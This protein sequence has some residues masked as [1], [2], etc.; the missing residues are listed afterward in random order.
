MN[1]II[2]VDENY[3]EYAKTM[4]FSLACNNDEKIVVYL[5][6]KSVSKP[7]L[8]QFARFMEEKCHGELRVVDIPAE[9]F[10]DLP[11][12]G[13]LSEETYYRLLAF[14]LL[15]KTVERALWLDADIIVKGNIADFY[16]TDFD[17]K[18]AAACA[19]DTLKNH[20]RLGLSQTHR[21]FNAGVILFNL[22]AM[23]QRF[24]PADVFSCIE[25]HRDHLDCM[26]QDVLNVLL[27]DSVKYVDRTTYNNGAFGFNILGKEKMRELEET[28][29]IIHYW[30]SVKPW[31][32]K[33]ANWADGY[34]WGYEWKR[35]DHYSCCVKYRLA[36]APVKVKHLLREVY[37]LIRGQLNRIR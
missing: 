29:R 2:A 11:S 24:S 31:N 27:M 23:R 26:D 21:Y 9:L 13:R 33:G 1:I 8:A 18:L 19:E 22:P 3:V 7:S 35:G 6:Q 10:A 15:P 32:R 30:G 36:N 25:R 20:E 14:E 28:A 17:G 34:W 37:Y 5:L 12:N 16:H 4:L